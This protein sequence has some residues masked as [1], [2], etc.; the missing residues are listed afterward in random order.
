ML[1]CWTRRLYVDLIHINGGSFNQNMLTAIL[2]S[3]PNAWRTNLTNLMNL[4]TDEQLLAHFLEDIRKGM[5]LQ[6]ASKICTRCCSS[7]R[8]DSASPRIRTMDS[9]MLCKS[10]NP[11]FFNYKETLAFLNSAAVRRD[12]P[13]LGEVRVWKGELPFLKVI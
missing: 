9:S 7:R 13:V 11:S 5:H 8:S 6:V 2:K 10:V 3:K 4:Q 1:M 12:K